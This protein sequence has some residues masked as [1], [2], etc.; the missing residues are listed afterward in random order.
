MSGWWIVASLVVVAVLGKNLTE[1]DFWRGMMFF[2]VLWLLRV[3]WLIL[4][5]LEMITTN[6]LAAP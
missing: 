6:L 4:A 1:Q 2:I 5:E 3:N